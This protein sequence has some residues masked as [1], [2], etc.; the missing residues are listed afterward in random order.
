MAIS[1]RLW[2]YGWLSNRR[3]NFQSKFNKNLF[4][5]TLLEERGSSNRELEESKNEDEFEFESKRSFFKSSKRP[6]MQKFARNWERIERHPLNT[7]QNNTVQT[8]IE[9]G[10]DNGS[11]N[12]FGN[13]RQFGKSWQ[14]FPNN[15][16]SPFGKQQQSQAFQR[17]W[18][19]KTI[20]Y[21]NPFRIFD[22]SGDGSKKEVFED[23]AL[24]VAYNG[25]YIQLVF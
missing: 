10:E 1:N 20:E 2:K 8:E 25:N 3:R 22:A 23:G 4:R 9:S 11:F 18:I 16:P 24:E 19:P 14:A 12:Q 15:F 6:W 5:K 17:N 7:V 21:F 13:K